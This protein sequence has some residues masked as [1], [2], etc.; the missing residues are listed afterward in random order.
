MRG[1]VVGGGVCARKA[2]VGGLGHGGIGDDGKRFTREVLVVSDGVG[3]SG[4]GGSVL[5]HGG[6]VGDEKTFFAGSTLTTLAP[7]AVS[8]RL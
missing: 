4:A 5:G 8:V 2:D 6:A 1:Q 3:S 7:G